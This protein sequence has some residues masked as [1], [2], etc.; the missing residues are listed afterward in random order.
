[1]RDHSV[2]E[3]VEGFVENKKL[4]RCRQLKDFLASVAR[5]QADAPK[6]N[7]FCSENTF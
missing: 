5:V 3:I 4:A 1:M 6:E 7:Q 2:D